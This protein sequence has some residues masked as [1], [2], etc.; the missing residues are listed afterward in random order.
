ATLAYH[1]AVLEAGGAAAQATAPATAPGG[2]R[3]DGRDAAR[4][5]A[6]LPPL[7]D[8]LAS[9]REVARLAA[10]GPAA[11]AGAAQPGSAAPEAIRSYAR[12]SS[13]DGS[14]QPYALRL[15]TGL[16]QKKRYALLLCLGAEGGSA[17]E[18]AAG[19]EGAGA[20]DFIVAAAPRRSGATAGV[21]ELSGFLEEL[22]AGLPVDPERVYLAGWREGADDALALARLRPGRF[23][24]VAAFSGWRGEEGLA[25][26]ART[27]ILLVVGGADTRVPPGA[28]AALAERLRAER[29]PISFEAVPGG[30][31]WE[32]WTGSE[33]PER[34]LVWLR[35][36][37]RD[38]W[39]E[40]VEL[41]SPRPRF[42]RADWL[43]VL[44]HE[45]P[46]EPA[47]ASALVVDERHL[48][49]ETENVALLTLDLRHPRLA[50]R[51]RI[52]LSIN[53]AEAT[54]DAG[55]PG[56][57]FALDP[58]DGRLRPLP[59][60][61]RS[62]AAPPAGIAAPPNGGGGVVDLRHRPLAIVYGTAKA[63][64]SAALRAL[65]E[66]LAQDLGV[67]EALEPRV[68]PD[69]EAAE[70]PPGSVSFL[71]VGGPESNRLTARLAAGLPLRFARGSLEVAGA[72]YP[73]AGSFLVR[74]NPEAPGQL[75][76]LLDLPLGPAA[77][78]S[79]LETIFAPLRR[80]AESATDSGGPDLLVFD[81]E[82]RVLRAGSYDARWEALRPRR[83]Q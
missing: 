36:R 9:Y 14:L 81:A 16:D 53:G 63:R 3:K 65:A 82:A 17:R 61:G 25:A 6:A 52:V 43:A 10:P 48:E 58:A 40:R 57:L 24:A 18:A 71:L 77:L 5:A 79:A 70:L 28:A 7:A 59:A 54:A 66:T 1:A 13:L 12:A 11:P 31:P 68:L 60:S 45:T 38:P 80:A 19:I 22:L 73:R 29:C 20:A 26:L 67:G 33:G 41:R 35:A 75:V 72:V 21:I 49:V 47:A 27:P 34:L 62:G 4:S 2:S 8:R 78:A 46:G 51:G 56:A 44:E 55:S 23:A 83:D 64:E 69:L 37:R 15:P 42:G 30:D 76:G 74:P 32:A 50:S 39:P